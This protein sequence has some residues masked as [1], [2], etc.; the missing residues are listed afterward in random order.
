MHIVWTDL[1]FDPL[2]HRKK[3]KQNKRFSAVRV[4]VLAGEELD[5]VWNLPDNTAELVMP[6][7]WTV[8]KTFD[9]AAMIIFHEGIV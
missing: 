8:W 4:E 5:Q 9:V 6:I 7:A 1:S 3:Q 2:Q